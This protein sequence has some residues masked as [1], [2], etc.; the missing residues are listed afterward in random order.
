MNGTSL[1]SETYQLILA[2]KI[3]VYLNPYI[4]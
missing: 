1:K 2:S 4:C 3:S